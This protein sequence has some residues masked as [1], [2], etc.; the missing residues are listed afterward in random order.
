M[1]HGLARRLGIY[2]LLRRDQPGRL[3]PSLSTTGGVAFCLLFSL[4]V[5]SELHRV[6]A[7]TAI[8]WLGSK[9]SMSQTNARISRNW[10]MASAM[11]SITRRSASLHIETVLHNIATFGVILLPV[12]LITLRA[13]WPHQSRYRSWSP[14]ASTASSRYMPSLRAKR[15]DAMFCGAISATTGSLGW[16]PCAHSTAARAASMA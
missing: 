1:A 4:D 15:A 11:K 12:R 9:T 10:A 13:V 8:S 6:P 7:R 16:T 2:P 5:E 14:D 3:N